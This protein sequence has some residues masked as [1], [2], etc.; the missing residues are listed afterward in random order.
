MKY[1][2]ADLGYRW[3]LNLNANIPVTKRLSFNVTYRLKKES[4][5]IID[6][7]RVLPED[8]SFLMGIRISI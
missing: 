1:F 5:S 2:Q 4:N 3:T 8:R 7:L 6:A